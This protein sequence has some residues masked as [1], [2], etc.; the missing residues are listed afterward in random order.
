[1][2]FSPN[3]LKLLTFGDDV[4]HSL[5]IYDWKNNILLATSMVDRNKVI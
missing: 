1:M 3:S 5:A 4:N 2:S